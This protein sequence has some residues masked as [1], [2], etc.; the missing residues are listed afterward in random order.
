MHAWRGY[1]HAHLLCFMRGK[2]ARTLC[3]E[4][5]QYTFGLLVCLFV[6]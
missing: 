6:Q 5:L 3:A 2:D 4:M 1:S